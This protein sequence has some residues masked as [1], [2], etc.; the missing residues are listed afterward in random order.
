MNIGD[1]VCLKSGGPV[2]TVTDYFGGP[3][4]DNDTITASW[5]NLNNDLQ[6]GVFYPATLKELGVGFLQPSMDPIGHADAAQPAPAPFDGN[7]A[8]YDERAEELHRDAIASLIKRNE[9]N[10]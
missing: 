6:S 9:R 3:T 8:G 10:G 1:V 4:P 7:N 5:F 2:M